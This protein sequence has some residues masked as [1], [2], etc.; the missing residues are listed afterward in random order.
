MPSRAL[1]VWRTDS[2]SKLDELIA[3][4]ARVGGTARGRRYA[5]EQLNA[6]LAVQVAAHF[7]LFCR[8]LHTEAAQVLVSAAPP[9]YRSMLRVAFTNRRGLDRG[10]ASPET[11]NGD[12]A[13]FDLD[14]WTAA[15]TASALTARRR[16]GLEQLT[17]WRNA[18]AHQD[19]VFSAQQQTLLAG[20][21]LTLA[22]ARRW[23]SNC[24]GLAQTF[25]KVV[26]QHVLAVTG[27]RPW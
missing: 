5:T 21:S 7:Q 19:F 27:R 20:T 22:W 14:I 10:N 2:A 1:T 24:L 17:T 8:N 3:A 16:T 18:I 9:R 6:S 12:F 15:H 11:I 4:H 23:R 25:D 26:G 13:R